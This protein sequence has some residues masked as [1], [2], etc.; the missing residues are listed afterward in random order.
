MFGYVKAEKSELRVWENETYKAVYC[1]LCRKLGKNYGPLARFTLNYDFTFLALLSMSLKEKCNKFDKKRCPFNP[2]KKCNYC[3][4]PGDDIELASG[5]AM[6]MLYYK[7]LDNKVDSR[8]IKKA[9]YSLLI[10]FF[11]R[12]HKKAIRLYPTVADIVKEYILRQSELE[13]ENCDNLD[14]IADPTSDALGKIF[15]MCSEDET[16]KRILHNLGYSLGKWIYLIDA[17][18][19]FSRDIKNGNYNPLAF[20]YDS[21]ENTKEYVKKRVEPILNTCIYNANLSINLLDIKKYRGII[22]NVICLGLSS[23]MKQVFS[24]EEK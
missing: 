6:V 16:Q 8:G 3:D 12:K 2:L 9:I 18:D 7:L 5:V 10:P 13:K 23:V 24:R 15:S 17:A 14:K 21:T 22:E 11:K 19:D 4:D 20:G 1:S